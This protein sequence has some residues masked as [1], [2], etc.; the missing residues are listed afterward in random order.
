MM[1]LGWSELCA[2]S[3]QQTSSKNGVYVDYGKN[4]MWQDDLNAREIRK[5]WDNAIEYCEN[6][7]LGGYSDWYLPNKENLETLYKQSNLLKN[8]LSSGYWSSTPVLGK[9]DSSW[10]VFFGSGKEAWRSKK[11]PLNVRCVRTR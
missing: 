8:K 9:N 10:V 4:L 5:N 2:F 1:L 7:T 6:L 11:I 3:T